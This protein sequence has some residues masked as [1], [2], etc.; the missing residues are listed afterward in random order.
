[1]R[2]RTAHCRRSHSDDLG[3]LEQ[4][5]RDLEGGARKAAGTF[6]SS[7]DLSRISD[8]PVVRAWIGREHI[9][10][11]RLLNH[12]RDQYDVNFNLEYNSRPWVETPSI[13]LSGT[14]GHLW[15][16]SWFL[17]ARILDARAYWN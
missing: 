2:N 7:G 12:A 1:I 15:H 9:D 8:D 14:N 10:A 5:L 13:G 11:V 16:V 6:N 17:G 3:R 4:T